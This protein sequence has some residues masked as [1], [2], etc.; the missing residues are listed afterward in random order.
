MHNSNLQKTV[1]NFDEIQSMYLPNF[2]ST[3]TLTFNQYQLHCAKKTVEGHDGHR[4]LP[5]LDT[6]QSIYRGMEVSSCSQST[7][8][9]TFFFVSI[10]DAPTIELISHG[11]TIQFQT[12]FWSRSSGVGSHN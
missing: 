3:T 9:E 6:V 8:G 10:T 2:I 11:Y 5:G 4:N 7:I 1:H 12:T